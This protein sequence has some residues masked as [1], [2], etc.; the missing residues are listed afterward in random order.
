MNK[1]AVELSVQTMI[2]VALGLIVLVVLIFVIRGQISKGASQ[3]FDIGKSAAEEAA[4]DQ[5][6]SG[7]FV[8]R[9]CAQNCA[10]L[11]SGFYWKAV[12]IRG[13]DESKGAGY[14]CCERGEAKVQKAD[15][16]KADDKKTAT[17]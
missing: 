7:L 1:K 12:G 11:D 3:Y 2:I 8:E 17:N 16:K 14:I 15:D 4:T 5:C 13:C 9:K 10:S 6:K